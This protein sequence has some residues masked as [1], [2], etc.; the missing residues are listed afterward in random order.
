MGR[1]IGILAQAALLVQM[2]TG[3]NFTDET[4]NYKFYQDRRVTDTNQNYIKF[5]RAAV[6][7][8]VK[9]K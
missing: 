1:R 2:N 5:Y 6:N 4:K 8:T 9:L 7:V 3:V